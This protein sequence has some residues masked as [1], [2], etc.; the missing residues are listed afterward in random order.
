MSTDPQHHDS[1][2]EYKLRPEHVLTELDPELQNAILERNEGRPLPRYLCRR[3]AEDFEVVD[4]IAKL[5]RPNAEVEGLNVSQRIGPIVT[6]TV[7]VDDIVKVRKHQ[8]VLSLKG[9]RRLR[10]TLSSSV[11]EINA[12]Q[13]QLRAA[14]AGQLP[15]DFG[16]VDGSGVIVGFVDHGCDFAHRNFR[17]LVEGRPGPTRILYL[18]DQRDNASEASSEEL[19]KPPCGYDYGRE[20]GEGLL[21]RAL[22]APP[23]NAG[24]LTAPL[25]FLRYE[26]ENE[27]GTGVMDVAAGSGGGMNPPGVAPGADIIFVDTSADAAPAPDAPFGNSRQLLE[28]VKYIFDKACKLK[29]RAVVNISQNHDGGPHD[30]TTPVEEALD[31]LLETPGRAIVIAA[32]NSRLAKTHVRRMVHP[33]QS[34]TLFWEVFAGDSTDNKIEVWC[35]GRHRLEVTLKS[36]PSPES[37]AGVTLDP[38]R[39]GTTATILR[40]REEAGRISYEKA[41][42][43]FNRLYDSSN[44]DNH[45]V[46][47]LDAGAQPG[48]WEVELRALG[49]HSVAPFAVHAWIETDRPRSEF[50]DARREERAYTLGTLACG[51]SPIVVSGG[52]DARD[53]SK[54]PDPTQAEGPTRDGKQ[55]PEVSAPGRRVHV[56]VAKSDV[57]SGP[58]NGTSLAAP[59]VTGLVALLMQVAPEPLTIEETRALVIGGARRN[60]PSPHNAW[61]P[62]YG[63]GRVD[64]SA[65]VLACVRGKQPAVPVLGEVHELIIS[66][67]I[68]SITAGVEPGLPPETENF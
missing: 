10:R 35:G 27:H 39:P 65:S 20:F 16:D 23:Q 63:A 58:L 1:E 22:Q 8:D 7:A 9:A 52:Y 33:N 60:P 53:D 19:A 31:L 37:P 12:S 34:C 47:L 2:V 18:W 44:G 57:L 51:H 21:N 17:K 67:T 4:V 32:G 41:G 24:D 66:E 59:H 14:L 61:D 68:V 36:P 30:G 3:L 46:V 25:R 62:R 43:I 13:D 49:D 11:P 48:V 56:A 5:R 50:Q 45:I 38:V 40:R 28:G 15:E 6:G 55:K 64:A 42:R 29:K 54:A 26:I